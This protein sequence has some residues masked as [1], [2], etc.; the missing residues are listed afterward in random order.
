MDKK[1]LVQKYRGAVECLCGLY[2]LGSRLWIKNKGKMNR[3][4]A[5]CAL[6][7]HVRIRF[8]GSGNTVRVGDFSQLDNVEIYINGDN[9]VVEIG[10]WCHLLRTEFCEEDEKNHIS[11]GD[12]TKIL[13]KTHFAAIE[14]TALTV[15]KNCLFSGD[16]HFRTG[17]SHAVLDMRGKRINPSQDIVLGDHVWVGTKTTFLKGAQVGS[18]SIVGACAVVTDAHPESNCVLAGVPAR[19]VKRDINWDINRRIAFAEE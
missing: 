5:P 12:G 18:D 10:A 2:N 16:I 19:V 11:I 4:E 6:L 15:G 14:S 17:D 9:N 3:V 13:G 7:K 1:T 8:Y